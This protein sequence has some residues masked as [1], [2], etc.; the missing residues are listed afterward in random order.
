MLV[1]VDSTRHR[2]HLGCFFQLEKLL[3]AYSLALR[4]SPKMGMLLRRLWKGHAIYFRTQ[5]LAAL[6]TEE[7]PLRSYRVQP[8][9][10]QH[11]ALAF[12]GKPHR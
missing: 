7:A 8:A 3:L 10:T 12:L 9:G 5:P 6:Q 1:H 11:C 2:H 4:G